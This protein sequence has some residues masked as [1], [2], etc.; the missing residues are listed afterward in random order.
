M[1]PLERV[2]KASSALKVF[3]LPSVVLFPGMALPLH[4]FE[5]R[6]RH[7]VKDSLA[8]DR[9]MA[10][11]LPEPGVEAEYAARPLLRPMCCAALIA[12]HQELG[13]GRYNI[14]LQGVARAR[15]GEELPGTK[16]YREVRAQILSDSIFSGPEEEQL[17]QTVFELSGRLPPTFGQTLLQNAARLSGG[18]LADAMAA[19]L[20][21]DIERRQELLAQLD[22]RQRMLGVL[23]EIG[24]LMG[25]LSPGKSPGPVN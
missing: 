20:V 19:A 22:V 2:E 25:R 7:L 1:T 17:R 16:R 9:V 10:M 23:D 6:Y 3:P 24:E 4:I 21:I 18:G 5:E 11:S 13:D 15:I 12:W 14:I 8:S